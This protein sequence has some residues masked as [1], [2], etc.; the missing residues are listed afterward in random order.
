MYGPCDFANPHWT[1]PITAMKLPPH[2]TPS[3]LNKIYDENPVPITGGVSLEG[4]APGPPDFSDPRQAFAL[5]QVANGTVM[6]AVY[7]SE[8]WCDVD[9][10][11]K[12]KPGF[13]PTYIVHGAADTKVPVELSRK[14]FAELQRQGIRCEMSEAS[15]EE[16][17]FAAKM[18][19]GSPTWLIQK[20][21]FDFLEGL[22]V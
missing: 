22:L 15:G 8:Q 19:V 20:R 17:T 5:S 2:L 7:Q 9:P 10:L 11:L 18:E 3:F 12:I 1:T 14:L 21:G 4:Q 6:K 16:H 13:P